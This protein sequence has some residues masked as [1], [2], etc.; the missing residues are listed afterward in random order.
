[1][2]ATLHASIKA[3]SLALWIAVCCLFALPLKKLGKNAGRDRMVCLC[4]QGI[5]RI[6]GI[7]LKVTG[8]LVAGRPLLL[9]TNHLSYLDIAIIGSGHAVRFT[10]K[11]EIA[12]WP[13]IGGIC[14]LCDAVFIDRR[15]DKVIEMKQATQSALASGAV[16]CLFPESSTGSG[17]HLLPFRSSLF[18][19]AEEPAGGCHLIVQPAAIAYRRIRRLPIDSVQWPRIAWYGDMNLVP[20]VWELLKLGPI[21]AE[22][23]FL[24]PLSFSQCR[25]RKEMAMQCRQAIAAAVEK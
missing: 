4:Y 2:I 7:R 6:I 24:P 8:A 5:L 13:V 3:M 22:M 18:S 19:L 21:D 23:I 9:V 14:R 11:S 15:P 10:P 12:T 1:V 25:D 16:V 20:H 17:V